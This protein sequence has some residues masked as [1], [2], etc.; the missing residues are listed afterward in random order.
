MAAAKVAG[1]PGRYLVLVDP[2]D[3]DEF[4]AAAGGDGCASWRE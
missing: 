2:G 1:P 3:H 4:L